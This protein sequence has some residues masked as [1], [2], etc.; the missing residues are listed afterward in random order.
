MMGITLQRIAFA[1]LVAFVFLCAFG[2]M[3]ALAQSAAG[4]LSGIVVDAATGLPLSGVQVRSLELCIT[5][6]ERLQ[7]DWKQS[8]ST[9]TRSVAMS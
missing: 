3:P 1:A 5:E 6:F 7:S 4:S 2:A 8:E 9:S